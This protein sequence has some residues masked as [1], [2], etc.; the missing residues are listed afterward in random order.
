[1]NHLDLVARAVSKH[2]T[3]LYE[4]SIL[5]LKET[6]WGGQGGNTSRDPSG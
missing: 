4:N 3:K 1:M 5:D 6:F 2:A